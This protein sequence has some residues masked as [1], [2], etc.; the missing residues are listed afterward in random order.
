VIFAVNAMP[1]FMPP[2]W[3]ILAFA[4][5]GLGLPM[6]PLAIG[7]ALAAASGRWVLAI[8]SSRYGRKLL[9][10]ERRE[11]L[12][13]M[14][15]WLE[16]R[17]KWAPPLA[18]LIYSFGPIPSNQLFIAAGLMRMPLGGIVAA[19][20]AGRL[21]SYPLWIGASGIAAR[22]MDELFSGHLLDA[23][24]M[25]LDVAL[26]AALVAFARIDWL[27]VIE[28][29]ERRRASSGSPRAFPPRS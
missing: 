8:A 16:Q 10:P 12:A 26:I 2:T 25:L 9:R 24:A 22:R 20:L 19:F 6:I 18:V 28:G 11:V 27:R 14:G 5:A 13:R 17:A 29:F 23:G 15:V 21:V 3:T 7:G 4:H 1:A